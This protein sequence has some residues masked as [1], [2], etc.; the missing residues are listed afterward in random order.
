MSY[1]NYYENNIQ[2][3]VYYIGIRRY[4]S[5]K[6]KLDLMLSEY[7]QN[8]K[9]IYLR[10]VCFFGLEKYEEALSYC[11]EAHENNYSVLDCNNLLGRINT[12]LKR[13]AEAE[14]NYLEALSINPH[15]AENIACYANLMLKTGHTKKAEKL[16]DEARRI[17]PDDEEVLR[18]SFNYYLIKNNVKERLKILERYLNSSDD[19]ISKFVRVGI[20]DL[21]QGHY[22]S[23]GENFRQAYL[24]DPTNDDILSILEEVDLKSKLYFLPLAIIN[25]VGGPAVVWAI[26]ILCALVLGYF[27]MYN[28][29]T[30]IAI[31]YILLAIYSWIAVAIYRIA[32][33]WRKKHG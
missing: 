8:G 7:P 12:E 22:K 23:A 11:K 16:L 27:E 32:Y 20:S 33:R 31:L 24:L 14:A 5:A 28:I 19:E 29:L 3:I 25:K 17:D 18:I 6:E 9:L 21:Y 10:S 4:N 1:E 15:S 26:F 13:Y 30:P 2:E